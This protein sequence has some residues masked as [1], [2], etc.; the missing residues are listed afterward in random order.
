MTL[1]S[2]VEE[3]LVLAKDQ[4]KRADDWLEKHQPTGWWQE[5]WCDEIA[6]FFCNRESASAF[7]NECVRTQQ[8]A[9]TNI[10]EDTVN[11]QPIRS[12]YEVGYSFLTDPHEK[13]NFRLEVMQIFDGFSPLHGALEAAAH[14]DG[15]AWSP[16]HASFKVSGGVDEYEACLGVLAAAGCTPALHCAST[17]GK[18]SY[19]NVPDNGEG[20]ELYLKPR[21]NLRDAS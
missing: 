5:W 8:W 14:L 11:T 13:E 2:V 1:G 4:C 20:I 7:V 6:F 12:T 21:I 17:Y 16:V 9:L 19:W 10:A 15:K 3:M 18:F